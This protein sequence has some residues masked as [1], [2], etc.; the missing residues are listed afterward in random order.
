M[1][2]LF[3]L[4]AFFTIGSVLFIGCK[5]DA[6]TTTPQNEISQATL[7][8]IAAHGFGTADVQKIEEGYLVEGDIIL[9]EEFLGQQPS[10]SLIRIA[11]N[12]QYRTTNLVNQNRT[13]TLALDS[14]LSAKPGYTEAL[15][16]VRDRYNAQ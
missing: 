12:E 4:L 10:G 9:T 7:S 13:I 8:S 6:G 14:K 16:V 11:N 1:K 5:K 3:T 15:A 2:Y